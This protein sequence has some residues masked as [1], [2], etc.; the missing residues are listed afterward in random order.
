LQGGVR[1]VR[2]WLRWS[3][4]SPASRGTEDRRLLEERILPAL[5]A[6]RDVGRVLFV[7]CARYTHHYERLFGG[8]E[9]W[10]IDPSRSRAR[11][12]ARRHIHDGLEHL[13]RHVPA[14]YFDAIVCN[15]VLGWGVDRRDVAEAA[16]AACHAALRPGGE[17]ILGWN[18][19]APR[20]RVDPVTLR[21]LACFERARIPGLD[22]TQLRIDAPHRHVFEGYRKPAGDDASSAGTAHGDNVVGAR[23][24][25]AHEDSERHA[26]STHNS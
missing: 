23:G 9:Y 15:G 19:V 26:P 22:A 25:G 14:A 4:A 16:F 17:L 24:V 8:Q 10:T 18:D 12:G 21:S 2:Y 6:R 7:G 11:W 1:N 5:A 3:R 20:N 13:G